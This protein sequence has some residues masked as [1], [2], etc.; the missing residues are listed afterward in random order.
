MEYISSWAGALIT[1]VV[2]ASFIE[3]FLPSGSIK[4]YVSFASGLIIIILIIK[5]ITDFKGISLPN[6]KAQ[7]Y[8]EYSAASVHEIYVKR[9]EDNVENALGISNVEISV[10]PENLTEIIYVKS[11]VKRK[12]IAEYLGIPQSRVGD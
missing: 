6:I 3:L 1:V 12:E 8:T 9:L 11:A 7:T 2:L 5:P 4:K 10:N